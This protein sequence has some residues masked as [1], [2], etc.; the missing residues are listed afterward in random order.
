MIVIFVKMNK[1]LVFLGYC[2]ATVSFSTFMDSLRGVHSGSIAY[3]IDF[4]GA[5]F[6]TYKHYKNASLIK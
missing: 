4:K 2:L 1:L 3:C 5:G 6:F